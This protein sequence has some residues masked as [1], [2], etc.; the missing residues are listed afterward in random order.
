MKMN[1]L[2]Q[3]VP[4]DNPNDYC[5]LCFS[6]R[7]L[8]ELFPRDSGP[9]QILLDLISQCTG[10]RI[11]EVENHSCS[12]CWRCAVAL[13]DFHMFRQRCLVHDVIIKKKYS[14]S[15]V[16]VTKGNAS[17]IISIPE[18]EAQSI[19]GGEEEEDE[20]EDEKSLIEPMPSAESYSSARYGGFSSTKMNE[21]NMSESH[22]SNSTTCHLC[23]HDFVSR[24]SLYAHFKEQHSDRGRPHKCDLCQASFKRRSHL[25]DHVSSHTGEIRYN[26]KDCG[27]K[28]AKSKSL[29]RHRKSAHPTLQSTIKTV[30][31]PGSTGG[32][33]KC[34]Y[35]PKSFRHR[36]SLN[37]HVKTHYDMLPHVCEF[38][39]A[40]FANEK[41]KQVHKGKYHP[42][43][44][45]RAIPPSSKEPQKLI[46][47]SLCPRY[48]E[49]RRYLTQHMK[50]IHPNFSEE[51]NENVE[52]TR[53][54]EDQSS[55]QETSDSSQL[56]HDMEPVTVKF[57]VEDGSISG[58][59]VENC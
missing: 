23:K 21:L 26:C 18:S 46:Q 52:A 37:F 12:I 34:K 30:D 59:A 24:Q 44:V 28:Y 47:C 58:T 13:E 16:N 22:S 2:E 31:K 17:W 8:V 49:Q 48:F 35:C 39:D 4:S 57:E 32:E 54:N 55:K 9:K 50:F 1:N 40:R 33:F 7:N 41:G 15:T 14:N 43:D 36:P 38:C 3:T 6:N 27:A 45:F 53:M 25:E 20:E 51:L 42:A 11:E 5:R 10:I 29:M 56:N 19:G